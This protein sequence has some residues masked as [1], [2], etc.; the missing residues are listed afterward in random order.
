MSSPYIGEIR[1][2]AGNFAPA[3]WAF[4]AGQIMPISENDALFNLIGTMY[5][6]DGQETFG[7]PNL[8]G[9]FPI[10]RSAEM[11]QASTGG[12]ESVTLT[13]GQIAAHNHVFQA[14]T[15]LAN[16]PTPGGN[17]PGQAGT[18]QWYTEDNPNVPMDPATLQPV[19]PGS[20]P[21]ENMHPYLVMNY[22]ISLYG[23]Y[24]PPN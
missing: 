3:G 11:Q 14:T 5:G 23:I 1:L 19:N 6:G 22:I 21:H 8:Q 18:F 7:L 24:P 10:H 13:S 15:S 20:Q 2:F 4:C 12:T 9:R 16:Q 17:V